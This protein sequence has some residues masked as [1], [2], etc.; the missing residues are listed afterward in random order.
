LVHCCCIS[1]PAAF[2]RKRLADAVGPFDESLRLVMD[3][4]YWLRAD[5][6]GGVLEHVRDV[7]AHTR[8]HRQTKTGGGGDPASFGDRFFRE[9]FAASLRHAGHVSSH[10]VHLWLYSCVFNRRPWT[11]RHEEFVTRVCQNWYHLRYRCG[12]SRW[13][14]ARLVLTSER[15][16]VF[17][18]L[19]RQLAALD[20]RGWVRHGGVPRLKLEPDR[21]LGPELEVTHMGGPVRL[22]G[23][24]ARDTTLR[25]FHG[26]MELTAVPLRADKPAE[27]CVDAPPGPLRLSFSEWELL[28]DGRRVSFKLT[29]TT[30]F[31]ERDVA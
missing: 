11:R 1:Q 18:Y 20:P 6:A 25:V 28:P 2:W 15:K 23:V 19:R 3:Y 4:D 10:H 12:L 26:A 22:A 27:V 16:Y 5:R 8:I 17:P 9:L 14:A 13:R 30:L 29:G 21:W 31:S 24:P 7:L